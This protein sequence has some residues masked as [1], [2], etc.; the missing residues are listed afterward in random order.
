M[1]NCS[2]EGLKLISD[3]YGLTSLTN[4]LHPDA[5]PGIRQM[6]M[7][8]VRMTCAMFNGDRNTVGCVTTGL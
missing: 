7:E 3:V 2:V 1:Y 6:E 5:F 8:V 4:P